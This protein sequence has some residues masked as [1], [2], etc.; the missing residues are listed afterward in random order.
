MQRR[1]SAIFTQL[2]LVLT[3]LGYLLIGPLA[4]KVLTPL[5]SSPAWSEGAPGIGFGVG[6]AGGMGALF[7]ISGGLALIA[8]LN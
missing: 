7:T 5:A 1:V 3:P 4:D 8:T 6:A 2:T